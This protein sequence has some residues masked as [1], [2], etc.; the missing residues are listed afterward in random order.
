MRV[1]VVIANHGTKNL[2]FLDEVLA[3]YRNMSYDV[4]IVVL[5]DR[6]KDFGPDVEVRV[7]APTE[8]PRSLPFAH[9]QILADGI[10]D[11]DLFVYSEDD[12]LVTE[13]N[14]RAF[15]EATRRL[16]TDLV[17]GF[18]RYEERPSGQRSYMAFHT[19]FRWDPSSATTVN[20]VD[21]ARYTNAH[22]AMYVLTR[23]QLR[24]AIDSGGYLV[25]PHHGINSLM[26]SA[27]TDVYTQCGLTR[28][29]CTS[30]IQEFLLHHL[31]NVYLDRL[32]IDPLDFGLQMHAL[33]DVREGRLATS[34]LL[35][36]SSDL[37]V[38]GRQRA[39]W[40]NRPF[41]ALR[42]AVGTTTGPVLSIGA[43]TGDLERELFASAH[44]VV[45]V[46]VDEVLGTLCRNRGLRTVAPDL[47]VAL[48]E[49]QDERF[50]LILLV[51][52]L[53]HVANPPALLGLVRQLLRP[54][55]RI[56]VTAPNLRRERLAAAMGRPDRVD[57]PRV[58][59]FGSLGV[60]HTDGNVLRSWMRTAGCNVVS[61]RYGDSRAPQYRSRAPLTLQ[62]WISRTA[63]VVG[64]PPIV[65]RV[66][67][68]MPEVTSWN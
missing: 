20:G 55:G 22:S 31:P 4:R 59:A 48:H 52:F 57:V 41:A 63:V 10:D 3:A 7:G 19:S 43:T 29:I 54:G 35:D 17:P 1:L 15:V 13:S 2:T 44:E 34:A 24:L 28:V 26:V 12:T 46:P 33:D 51:D 66:P 11:Y 56:V 50:E 61:E 47:E 53:K 6:P 25:P 30:A 68:P 67:E 18:L 36:G 39:V 27:A 32:G 14:L 60:H 64:A 49:L 23:D 38:R 45:A 58:G 16:P 42:A 40:S 9:Q 8:D 21:V 65:S 62:R 37:P 5:S